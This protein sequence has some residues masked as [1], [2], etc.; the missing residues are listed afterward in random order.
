MVHDPNS[1]TRGGDSSRDQRQHTDAPR[2]ALVV[3]SYDGKEREYE[4]FRPTTVIGRLQRCD[5]MVALPSVADQHC[6][7]VVDGDGIL[8]T[9]LGTELGT[10]INGE[11]VQTARLHNGDAIGIGAM[12]FRVRDRQH[13]TSDGGRNGGTVEPKQEAARPEIVVMPQSMKS[14]ESQL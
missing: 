12:R 8:V 10:K 2:F 4:L 5:L 1:E 9:D 6:E 13:L 3:R 14:I 11:R 7:I